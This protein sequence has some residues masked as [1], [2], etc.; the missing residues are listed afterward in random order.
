MKNIKKYGLLILAFFMQ[1]MDLNISASDAVLTKDL[2]AE[3]PDSAE[4]MEQKKQEKENIAAKK[5]KTIVSEN[6]KKSNKRVKTTVSGGA[7]KSKKGGGKTPARKAGL[8][9]SKRPVKKMSTK[10]GS[11]KGSKGGKKV[12]NNKKKGSDSKKNSDIVKEVVSDNF[13]V[14]SIKGVES[15]SKEILKHN[16]E[17]EKFYKE[18]T[19]AK[20]SDKAKLLANAKKLED[21]KKELEKAISE[22]IKKEINNTSDNDILNKKRDEFIKFIEEMHGKG[23]SGKEMATPHIKVLNDL[24]ENRKKDLI[25]VTSKKGY[26]DYSGLSEE[27]MN[28][29]KMMNNDEE[30]EQYKKDNSSKNDKTNQIKFIEALKKFRK[31]IGEIKLDENYLKNG[32]EKYKK[33][34]QKLIDDNFKDALVKG[35]IKINDNS[36]KERFEREFNLY[37]KNKKITTTT[38][39]DVER[40]NISDAVKKIKIEDINKDY[41]SEK[42]LKNKSLDAIYNEIVITNTSIEDFKNRFL[43][44]KKEIEETRLEKLKKLYQ[45]KLLFEKLNEIT[46]FESSGIEQY[47]KLMK[48]KF[49]YVKLENDIN[50]N[51]SPEKN[52]LETKKSVIDKVIVI[53]EKLKKEADIDLEAKLT[54]IKA[55]KNEDNLKEIKEKLKEFFGL[56]NTEFET[57]YKYIASV[58]YSSEFFKNIIKDLQKSFDE[59]VKTVDVKKG[60]E[61]DNQ[62]NNLIQ[63]SNFLNRFL[64][65][66]TKNEFDI[67]ITEK[68]FMGKKDGL[69]KATEYAKSLKKNDRKYEIKKLENEDENVYSE[70]KKKIQDKWKKSKEEI[71]EKWKNQEKNVEMNKKKEE[72]LGDKKIENQTEKQGLSG[73]TE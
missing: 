64:T 59:K 65:I 28:I 50:N 49:G 32:Y 13:D 23:V 15:I 41:A 54:S 48:E 8:N 58:F 3:V 47:I 66:K 67:L 55:L 35:K 53:L 30:L 6:V 42:Y 69:Q 12:S 71:K 2:L 36:L 17:I 16:A 29:F 73:N 14:S 70:R 25:L 1:I 20:E 43:E 60:Y 51:S 34:V 10:K 4:L 61:K 24:I 5:A 62:Y 11:S 21:E 22:E 31:S 72:S 52:N 18:A 37:K 56:F 68:R 57:D 9:K 39:L 27:Y 26:F 7:K 19:V 38:D 63:V 40:D 46:K 33:E 45:E 44:N